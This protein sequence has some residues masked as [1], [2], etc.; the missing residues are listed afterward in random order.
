MRHRRPTTGLIRNQRHT[1]TIPRLG[2]GQAGII[3]ATEATTAPRG[4]SELLSSCSCFVPQRPWMRFSGSRARRGFL[5]NCAI[6]LFDW[7]LDS[8]I[9]Y[10]SFPQLKRYAAGRIP[11]ILPRTV[12]KCFCSCDALATAEQQAFGQEL[13]V[14]PGGCRGGCGKVMVWFTIRGDDVRPGD[15]M[16]TR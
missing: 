15:G 16:V 4:R 1:A 14:V 2:R 12:F 10:I 9:H 8:H 3:H 13:I 6:R 7:F 5:S 11:N